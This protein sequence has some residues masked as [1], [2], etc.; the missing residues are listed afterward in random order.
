MMRLAIQTAAEGLTIR[1]LATRLEIRNANQ[2]KPNHLFGGGPTD[3]QISEEQN[4]VTIPKTE[5]A[6]TGQSEQTVESPRV[7]T[8]SSLPD[9]T[10]RTRRC[11]TTRSLEM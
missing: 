11:A 2:R 9:F 10:D 7:I 5:V 8:Y 4:S 6:G 1:I 3:C